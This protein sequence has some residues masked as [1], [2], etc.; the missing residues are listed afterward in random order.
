MW[1]ELKKNLVMILVVGFLGGIIGGI[2][3]LILFLLNHG[4]EIIW[5]VI[6]ENLNLTAYPLVV[7]ALGGVLVGLWEKRF[8]P[9]PRELSE[10][11][12]EVKSGEKVPYNNLHIVGMAALLPLVFGGS[13]GPEAG[14][15]GIIVGLCFW[16][17]DK[18]KFALAEVD[19]IAEIGMAATI[20]VIFNSPLFGFVNQIEDDGSVK[21]IP[22]NTKILLYFVGIL[23]GLGAYRLLSHAIGGGPGLGNFPDIKTLG[24][25]EWTLVIPLALAGSLLGMLYFIFKSI[26][27]KAIHPL[28][29]KVVVKAVVAGVILGGVGIFLPYTMFSGEHQMTGLMTGWESIGVGLLFVTAIV[30]LLITNIC[31]ELGWRGGHIFPVIFS[32]AAIGYAFAILLPIDPIFCVAVVASG[33]TGAIL[34]K[35]LAVI[36]LLLIMFPLSAIIPLV[37]GAVIGS[38]I[39]VPGFLGL[40]QTE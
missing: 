7:C 11:M 14:L 26:V 22:K 1:L 3:W 2:T 37:I 32:G 28:K 8:G 24:T 38:A 12:A 21:K 10:I 20:G 30:K 17:S 40:D 6:P 13:L 36:L 29:D 19:E 31:L 18:L 23:G 27:K 35:P 25:N 39:P 33:L 9:Y 16:F 4:I 5:H 34:R 15:S